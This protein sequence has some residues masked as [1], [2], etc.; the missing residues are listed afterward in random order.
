MNCKSCGSK[1]KTIES[2]AT[3]YGVRRRHKCEV[4]GDRIT[5]VEITMNEYK[6]LVGSQE[7]NKEVKEKLNDVYGALERIGDLTTEKGGE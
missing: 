6:A 4:C 1:L 5:T 7:A 3:P 2:R